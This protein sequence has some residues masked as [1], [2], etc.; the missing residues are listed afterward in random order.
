MKNQNNNV[1]TLNNLVFE[2]RNKDYGAYAL[3][4]SYNGNAIKSTLITSGGFLLLALLISAFAGGPPAIDD[5]KLFIIDENM[6]NVVA[7]VDVDKTPPQEQKTAASNAAPKG[8]TSYTISNTPPLDTTNNKKPDDQLAIVN[9]S[10]NNANAH[11]TDLSDTSSVGMPLTGTGGGLPPKIVEPTEKPLLWAEEMPKFKGDL[12]AFIRN[13]IV[14]PEDA[15]H[16]G[17]NGAVYVQFVVNED[18]NISNVNITKK[19]GYGCDE[20]AARVVAK[21]PAWEP[22]KMGKKP[23]KVLYN[24]PIKFKAN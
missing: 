5:S 10:S 6:T 9:G 14:F 7:S 23:V 11:G 21:M 18:G 20:E 22:G 15:I 24:I 13:N 16:M 2:R 3:R 4:N 1:D 19:V 17:V 8:V 12:A